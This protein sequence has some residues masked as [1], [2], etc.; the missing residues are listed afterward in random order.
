MVCEARATS[1]RSPRLRPQI[2]THKLVRFARAQVA[3]GAK[4][5]TCQKIGET[6]VM[7]GGG[8]DDILITYYILAPAR[9]ARLRALSD[10]RLLAG[11]GQSCDRPLE[12]AWGVGQALGQRLPLVLVP[13]TA[14]I[15]SKVTRVAILTV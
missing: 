1:G 12:Q 11:C 8:L 5:I 15:G 4:G 6:E 2:K 10:R 9:L 14:E 7:A 3:A 13:T